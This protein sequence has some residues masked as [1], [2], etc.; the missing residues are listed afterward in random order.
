MLFRYPGGKGKLSHFIVGCIL[1]F[2][3]SNDGNYEY[4]EPFFGAGAIGWELVESIDCRNFW[5]NDID[6]AIAAIW[7]CII[8]D[9]Q[10]IIDRIEAFT[11]TVEAFCKFKSFLLKPTIKESLAPIDEVAFKKIAIH[12]ISYSGLGTMSGGPLGGMNQLS[13]YDIGCRWN[14]QLLVNRINKLHKAIKSKV[15]YVNR[16]TSVDF[17]ILL[18]DEGPAFF[19]LDPPYYVKGPILYEH[20]FVKTDH[21]RLA[22]LLKKTLSPWLLSYDNCKEIREL[23]SFAHLME[24]DINY[25]VNIAGKDAKKTELLIASPHYPELLQD[26]NPREIDI[27]IFGDGGY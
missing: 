7:T 25:T 5:I 12:Q 4:R 11:P 19:Y 17:E 10:S 14:A 21:E 20:S 3:R 18:H 15:V 2:Y 13:Q 9:P 1:D 27:D 8:N 26:K 23:Y 16:C 24:I 22:N 6:R